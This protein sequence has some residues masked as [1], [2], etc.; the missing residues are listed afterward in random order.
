MVSSGMSILA[1]PVGIA[2]FWAGAGWT[3]L[4]F[5]TL[6]ADAGVGSGMMLSTPLFTTLYF[7][8]RGRSG[9]NTLDEPASLSV[10]KIG[11]TSCD[12]VQQ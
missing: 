12:V 8:G 5:V 6:G 11:L 1:R 7:D 3:G 2:R 4:G 9:N 10:F